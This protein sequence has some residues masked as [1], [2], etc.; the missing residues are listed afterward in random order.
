ML[1]VEVNAQPRYAQNKECMIWPSY[2]GA[3]NWKVCA[4]ILKLVTDKKEA[5]ESILN[6]FV[7]CMSLIMLKGKVGAVGMTDE[8]AMGYYLNIL[9]SKPY[10]LQVVTSGMSGMIPV[11]T[12]VANALY[13]NRVQHTPHWHTP[14]GVTTVVEVKYVMWTGLQLQS[15]STTNVLPLACAR[16]EATRKK[17]VQV[18]P[19]DH[20][21]IM[22]EAS[23]HD[24]LEYNDN[25]MT[26]TRA[27][28]KAMKK[29]RKMR[30]SPR[31]I[32]KEYN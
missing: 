29:A 24:R 2:E 6:G 22:E 14:F 20:K 19:L 27:R 9:L 28:K 1:L 13:F 7:A 32:S 25:T 31:V 8:A 3:N 11:G 18:S 4:L 30:E 15:I 26:K 23:K 16:A 21:A 17:A 5:H 10:I 12:M